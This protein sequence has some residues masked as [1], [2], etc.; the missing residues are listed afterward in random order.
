LFPGLHG[1]QVGGPRGDLAF[2]RPKSH[3]R[4]HRAQHRNDRATDRYALADSAA[5]IFRAPK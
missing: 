4:L 2:T 1:E 3:D 5:L